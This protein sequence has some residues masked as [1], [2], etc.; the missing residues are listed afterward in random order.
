MFCS[1]ICCSDILNILI[2]LI[3]NL[4]LSNT[5]SLSTEKI[6]NFCYFIHIMNNADFQIVSYLKKFFN[7]VCTGH[8]I[9]FLHIDVSIFVKDSYIPVYEKHWLQFSLLM[10]IDSRVGIWW[11]H[12]MDW[13]LMLL[14]V[15]GIC[16]YFLLNFGRIVQSR[17]LSL[18]RNSKANLIDLINIHILFSTD[19]ALV[20]HF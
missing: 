11:S 2:I 5:I 6:I 18:D 13:T 3:I 19:W 17:Y 7:K 15:G 1:F 9:L 4:H 8:G 12:G 20:I 16:F 14:H 10:A